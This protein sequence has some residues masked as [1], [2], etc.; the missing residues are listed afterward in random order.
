M[1]TG[2][3]ADLRYLG[4]RLWVYWKP[5]VAHAVLRLAEANKMLLVVLCSFS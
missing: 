2:N 1:Q 3:R 5:M 4:S